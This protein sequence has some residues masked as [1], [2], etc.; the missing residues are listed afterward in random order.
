MPRTSTSRL[1]VLLAIVFVILSTVNALK[2][3]GDAAVFF[4]GGRRFLHAEPLYAGSSAADGFIGPPFQAMFFAPFAA[5]ASASPVAAK[6]LW[7]ALNVV[8]LGLGIWLSM[9]AWDAVRGQ[10]GLPG[11][12][13]LTMLFAPLIAI[14][15]PLQT[16]FEHQN[17][18]TVLLALIAGA[19]WQLT[20]GSAAVGGLLIGTATALKAFP[21]L[22]ILYLAARRYWT[23][24]ITAVASAFVLSVPISLGVYGL[25]GF[26]DLVS[27]FWRLSN[28]GWP[29]RGNNQS[30]IAAL[31][32]LTI[33]T[34]TAGVEGTG[35]RVM[36]EAPL[37]AALFAGVAVLLMAALV[38]VLV[39][40]PK[41]RMSIPCE[42]TAVTVLAILLSPI[43]WDHY[44]TMMFPAFLILHE[45]SD[46]AVLGR[47]ARYAF[48]IAAV[49]TTGLSPL[50]LG[51]T[52]FNLSR[53][54]RPTRWL[55]SSCSPACWRCAER[56]SSERRAASSE[57]LVADKHHQP[58]ADGGDDIDDRQEGKRSMQTACIEQHAARTGDGL[59]AEERRCRT[60]EG[61]PRGDEH[62]ALRVEAIRVDSRVGEEAIEA[63]S[64]QKEQQHHPRHDHR[65]VF[66]CKER[67]FS[68][69]CFSAGYSSRVAL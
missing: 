38:M 65:L 1:L 6:L 26:S 62:V 20:L 54:F 28:S 27:A 17:M 42:V 24:A 25:S 66:N 31:D 13:W 9:K 23:A 10:N 64:R 56:A 39:R 40:T 63:L 46:A 67:I 61:H 22:L 12:S 16:N 50:T 5:V 21:A 47:P 19:T 29:I 11:R 8:C 48:W 68:T 2:K 51:R 45:C 53:I 58:R 43:A 57:Q 55:R 41:Q 7:H 14:L 37:A 33:G 34:L 49:L 15:L 4:E 60:D 36:S 30:L 32:R 44:W 18:N 35:V 52:G 3:G 59:G 69:H